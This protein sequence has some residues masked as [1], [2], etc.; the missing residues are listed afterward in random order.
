MVKGS[1]TIEESAT[2]PPGP[3]DAASE[4]S[5]LLSNSQLL[6]CNIFVTPNIDHLITFAS[7][8]VPKRTSKERVP[9]WEIVPLFYGDGSP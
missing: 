2:M 1:L 6:L 4:T 9:Y 3:K 8:V 7:Q 5:F